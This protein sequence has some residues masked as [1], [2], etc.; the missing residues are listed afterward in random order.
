MFTN[1]K[2]KKMLSEKAVTG[3]LY[4]SKRYNFVPYLLLKD[5]Y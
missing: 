4:I 2:I 3:I 5:V 1:Y